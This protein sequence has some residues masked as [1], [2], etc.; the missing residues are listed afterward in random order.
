MAVAAPALTGA[1]EIV[2]TTLPVGETIGACSEMGSCT[3][4]GR[5]FRRALVNVARK[6]HR[7]RVERRR[8]HASLDESAE[9]G[10]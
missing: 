4:A 3:T 5:R 7:P 6:N 8:Q 2:S 9:S 10:T 1:L